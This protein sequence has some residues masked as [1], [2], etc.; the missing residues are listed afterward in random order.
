L[1]YFSHFVPNVPAHTFWGDENDRTQGVLRC[2]IIVACSL[3]VIFEFIQMKAIGP[4]SYVKDFWNY[5][6]VCQNIL[7]L[8]IVI[9]HGFSLHVNQVNLVTMAS[10][11]IVL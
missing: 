11:A 2:L 3:N 7:S 1:I 8:I 6:I 9:Y 4:V 10:I 5:I